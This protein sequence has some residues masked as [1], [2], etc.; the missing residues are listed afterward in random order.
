MSQAEA[1]AAGGDD[2]DDDDDDNN[3]ADGDAGCI[4]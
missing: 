4:E 3:L 1:V 2:D